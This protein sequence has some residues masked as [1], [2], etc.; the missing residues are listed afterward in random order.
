MSDTL[1]EEGLNLFRRGMH[2]EALAKFEAAAAS[3]AEDEDAL[4]QGEMLN[5]IGVV[6]RVRQNWPAAE[7]AFHEALSKFEEAGDDNRR[8]QVLGNLGDLHAFQGEREEAAKHYSDG[9]ELMAKT[10]DRQKQAQLLRALSLLRLRQ[11]RVVEA[12]FLMEESLSTRPRLN[13]FQRFFRFLLR[14]ALK[15]AGGQ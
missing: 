7:A 5:N 14:L 9:A 4:G 1:K 10:G 2:D 6:Q 13:P 3:Y 15:L 12:L 8:A 11:R